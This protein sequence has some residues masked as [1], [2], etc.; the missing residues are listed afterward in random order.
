MTFSNNRCLY[1][2]QKLTLQT[3]GISYKRFETMEILLDPEFLQV[4]IM[5][6]DFDEFS[7]VLA[8]LGFVNANPVVLGEYHDIMVPREFHDITGSPVDK[9]HRLLKGLTRFLVNT[10]VVSSRFHTTMFLVNHTGKGS[11]LKYSPKVNIRMFDQHVYLLMLQILKHRSNFKYDT[12]SISIS[13]AFAAQRGADIKGDCLTRIFGAFVHNVLH[14]N[15]AILTSGI[16]QIFLFNC[17]RLEA[18]VLHLVNL[19]TS[20]QDTSSKAKEFRSRYRAFAKKNNRFKVQLDLFLARSYYLNRVKGSL[21]VDP[22]NL[23]LVV[24][25]ILRNIK[26]ITKEMI[27]Y[28]HSTRRVASKLQTVCSRVTVFWELLHMCFELLQED[29]L[30][31]LY[32]SIPMRKLFGERSIGGGSIKKLATTTY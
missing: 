15:H 14:S 22:Q 18:I 27:D 29:T 32:R 30:T 25:L 17:A 13:S 23:L 9:N 10:L 19:R 3:L 28:K 20:K 16:I 1:T 4:R 24:L 31:R 7:R 2:S 12:S 5:N 8:V 11:K 26:I 21:S 6:E